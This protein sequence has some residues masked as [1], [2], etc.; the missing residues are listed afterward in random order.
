MLLRLTVKYQRFLFYDFLCFEVS[1]HHTYLDVKCHSSAH[2]DI[3]LVSL[4][5]LLSA[6]SLQGTTWGETVETLILLII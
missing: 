1:C 2:I 6:C 3:H 5:A 4:P